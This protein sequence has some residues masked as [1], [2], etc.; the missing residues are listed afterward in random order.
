MNKHKDK[1]DS[2]DLDVF[3]NYKCDG[4]LKMEFNDTSVEI[5]EEWEQSEDTI[6]KRL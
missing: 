2:S 4:Q 6:R 3:D 1:T 5:V